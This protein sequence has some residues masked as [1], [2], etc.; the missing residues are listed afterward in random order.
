[1]APGAGGGGHDGV[2]RYVADAVV[3]CDEGGRVLRPGTVEVSGGTISAV[4]P[5][6]VAPDAG[7]DVREIRVHGALLPG[8]VNVH[9]H[10]PMTL[11]RGS[12]ENLSLHRWLNDVLWPREAHLTEEDVYWGMT[13]AAAEL[14]CFGVTTTCEAYFFEDALADAVL[15]AGSRAVITPGVLQLPGT[16]SPAGTGS[17][18]DWW[19]ARTAEIVDF[20]ARRHGEDGRIEVGFAPHAAYTVPVPVLADVAEEARR[21]GALFHI[22]LAETEEEGIRFAAE[23]GDSVPV[24]LAEAGVFG[25]RVLA[26]HSIWLSAE[27]LAV[28]RSHDLAVAHC[29]QSNAKLAS[30]VAPLVEFLA[31]GTRVGLGTDGPASNN[32]LDMWEEMR[33]AAMLARIRERDAA[34]LPAATA[35]DLATRGAGLALGR[36]DLGV[37]AV[38]ARADMLAV[39]LDDPAFV[40]LLEDAQLIEHLVWSASSRLVTD[41]WVG[42]RQVVEAGRCLTV[43]VDEARHQVEARAHRLERAGG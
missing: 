27:D 38:G 34:V 8:L 39:T 22:H 32:D 7:R 29:P 19:D 36:P 15:A 6:D 5:V 26:A 30:G 33:L 10:S 25:G 4:G 3:P 12:G 20:H 2:V 14:L 23:H 16:G 35:L 42:G 9:C 37:L 43:D 40:P 31:Q 18:G 13:L 28:Y 11:F 24:V 21:L 41:V 1:M 17:G